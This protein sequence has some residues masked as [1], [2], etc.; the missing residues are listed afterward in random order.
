M[1]RFHGVNLLRCV[2]ELD[3]IGTFVAAGAGLLVFVW[4]LRIELLVVLFKDF[5]PL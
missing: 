5:T 3:S 2:V 4:M 1:V